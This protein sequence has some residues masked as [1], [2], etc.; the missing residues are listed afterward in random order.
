M[1]GLKVPT[2]EQSLAF[3]A[4]PTYPLFASYVHHVAKLVDVNKFKGVNAWL[5][6]T[7]EFHAY[8][9][10]NNIKIS[11]PLQVI[12]DDGQKFTVSNQ[13]AQRNEVLGA[14]A[15]SLYLAI[16]TSNY[17][18]HLIHE[19]EDS[20][21]NITEKMRNYYEDARIAIYDADLDLSDQ[22]KA[23]ISSLID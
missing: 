22:E 9:D 12:R 21:E 16:I 1:I 6:G 10:P 17:L 15:F 2:V 7:A 20:D 8:S 14:V 11:L 18:V 3:H 19:D 13:N 23:S 4:V 5:I